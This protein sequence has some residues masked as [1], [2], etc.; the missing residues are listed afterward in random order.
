MLPPRSGPI[1]RVGLQTPR[2]TSKSTRSPESVRLAPR[3]EDLRVRVLEISLPRVLKL[4]ITAV[5]KLPTAK[6]LLPVWVC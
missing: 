2:S 4:G 3:Y 1:L 6:E 5:L